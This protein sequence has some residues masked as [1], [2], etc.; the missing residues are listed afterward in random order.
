MWELV[1]LMKHWIWS[2]IGEN[3]PTIQVSAEKNCQI[4][5]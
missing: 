3:I 4:C 1:K 5:I 2:V